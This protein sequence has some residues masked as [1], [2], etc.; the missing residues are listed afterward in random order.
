MAPNVVLTA[1]HCVHKGD[2]DG[3]VKIT[4]AVL[5]RWNLKDTSAGREIRIDV[6]DMR[7]HSNYNPNTDEHDVALLKLVE[8]T[9]LPTVRLNSGST[10]LSSGSSLTTIGWGAL[11]IDGPYP[12]RLHQVQVDY[13]TNDEC[14]KADDPQRTAS[15]Q[16]FIH[17]DMMCAG[18]QGKDACMGTFTKTSSCVVPLAPICTSVR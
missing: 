2:M 4:T 8:S 16:N 10:S 9:S 15:Y 11:G 13:M 6:N 14:R 17:D 7:M 18:S 1:A 5:G 12:D 3:N